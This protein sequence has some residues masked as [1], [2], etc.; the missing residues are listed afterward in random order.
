MRLDAAIEARA[1]GYEALLDASE[2]ERRARF[3]A[4][5]AALQHLVGRALVR[6]SLSRYADVPPTA[7]RFEPNRYGCPAVAAPAGTDL[8][9]N[10]SHTDGLVACAVTRGLAVGVDVERV[11]RRVEVEKLARYSFAPSEAQTLLAA[12]EEARR[13]L[14]FAYWTLKE[15]YIKARG[16][17]LALPLDGFAFDIAGPQPTV[18]FADTCPDDPQ[19]WLFRRGRPTPEHRLALAVAHGG[20]DVEIACRWTVPLDAARADEERG[21]VPL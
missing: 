3:K 11:E 4:E 17:G 20:H 8:V 19:A 21:A 13:E 16:M 18:A 5:G 7:W 12:P 2:R 6:C 1:A 10:L 14:F 15:A 9:F